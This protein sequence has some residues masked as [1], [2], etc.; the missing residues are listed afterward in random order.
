[1]KG[2][3][4]E[5]KEVG[6]RRGR[7]CIVVGRRQIGMFICDIAEDAVMMNIQ[8][9]QNCPRQDGGVYVPNLHVS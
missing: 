2:W 1:M 5:G 9:S 3:T 4:D 6:K 7:V 8:K